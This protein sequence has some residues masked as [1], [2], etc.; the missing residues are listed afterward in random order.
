MARRML[1]NRRLRFI[2]GPSRSGMVAEGETLEVDFDEGGV[3]VAGVCR[4]AIHTL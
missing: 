3:G 2:G 1:P 4:D